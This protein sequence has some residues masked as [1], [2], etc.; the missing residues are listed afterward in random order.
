MRATPAPQQPTQPALETTWVEDEATPAPSRKR[1]IIVIL[2]TVVTHHVRCRRMGVERP[3]AANVRT[4][5]RVY[6]DGTRIHG[7]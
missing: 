1:A 7:Q 2:I 6:A 4:P 5:A 3:R